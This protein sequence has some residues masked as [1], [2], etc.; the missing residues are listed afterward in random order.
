MNFVIITVKPDNKA[1]F[2]WQDFWESNIFSGP[3]KLLIFNCSSFRFG[4]NSAICIIMAL[5]LLS[6]GKE[7]VLNKVTLFSWIADIALLSAKLVLLL[8]FCLHIGCAHSVLNSD[9]SFEMWMNPANIC[10]KLQM[11]MTI[12]GTAAAM[13]LE[14]LVD[15]C[16]MH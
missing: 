14:F 9:Y 10:I 8:L 5:S 6:S 3:M 12:L 11:Y 4:C 13:L 16:Q 15:Y 7:L 2:F 1:K